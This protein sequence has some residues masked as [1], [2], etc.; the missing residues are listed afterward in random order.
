MNVYDCDVLCFVFDVVCYLLFLWFD[1][2]MGC[3][4][5]NLVGE[6]WC[7]VIDIVNGLIDEGLFVDGGIEL[8]CINESCIGCGYCYL[9]VVE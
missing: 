4:V 3:F 8:L 2:C 7:Y 6:L 5:D 9:Y 1:V